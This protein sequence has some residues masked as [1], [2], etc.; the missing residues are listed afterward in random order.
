MYFIY[1]QLFPQSYEWIYTQA[2]DKTEN[3]SIYKIL[4]LRHLGGSAAECL[5]S[6]QGVVPE[7]WGRVLHQAPFEEPASSSVYVSASHE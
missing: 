5:P 4:S 3:V 6:A 7:S 2:W 1:N